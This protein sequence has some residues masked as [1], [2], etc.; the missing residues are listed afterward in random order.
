[1]QNKS[2]LA[3]EAVKAAPPITVTGATL[4]GVPVNELVLWATLAYLVLQMGFL[5][6]KWWRIHTDPTP[7]PLRADNE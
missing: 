5:V 3:A 4:A 6:Y 1:M 2:D 7:L